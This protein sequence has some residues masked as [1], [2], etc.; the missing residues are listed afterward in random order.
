MPASSHVE[1]QQ[2]SIETGTPST[3]KLLNGLNS[4]NIVGTWAIINPDSKSI[5]SNNLT[6][7]PT[8]TFDSYIKHVS[9]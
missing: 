3:T 8:I 7:L 1:L 4:L 6:G 5:N 9:E 2:P